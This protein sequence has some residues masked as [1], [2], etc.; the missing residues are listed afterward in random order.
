MTDAT[1]IKNRFFLF[2]PAVASALSGKIKVLTESW[3]EF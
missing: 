1:F 3:Q 2:L